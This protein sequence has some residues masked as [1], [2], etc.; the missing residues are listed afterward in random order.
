MTRVLSSTRFK[1]WEG[2]PITEITKQDVRDLLS[3][4]LADGYDARANKTLVVLRQVFNWAY[5]HDK[6]DAV[7][8]DRIK[9][10]GAEH[11]R[12]RALSPSELVAIWNACY[13]SGR[14]HGGRD[15]HVY[16]DIVRV[17]MLTGQRRN[18]VARMQW[19]EIDFDTRQID[20]LHQ[21][22]QFL[23]RRDV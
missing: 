19:S 3:T 5:D 23:A 1:D 18:E 16:G 2:R 17:L 6:I 9:P 7:P 4:I 13:G 15:S 10:P 11:S 20:R 8:T 22:A 21:V 14:G 12:D